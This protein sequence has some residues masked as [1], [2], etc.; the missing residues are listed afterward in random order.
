[1]TKKQIEKW[2]ERDFRAAE[3]LI[4]ATVATSAYHKVCEIILANQIWLRLAQEYGKCSP[5]Q[6]DA[7]LTELTNLRKTFRVGLQAHIDKFSEILQLVN[8]H[9]EELPKWEANLIFFQTLGKNWAGFMQTLG[10]KVTQLATPDLFS[11]V[12]Q[13]RKTGAKDVQSPAGTTFE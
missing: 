1:M 7:A 9:A 12:T 13:Y 6:H 5:Q 10:D 2:E 8:Y 4:K 3:A 11:T